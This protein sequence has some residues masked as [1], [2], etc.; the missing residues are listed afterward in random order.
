M[1]VLVN[2]MIEL[3]PID[4]LHLSFYLVPF[5]DKEKKEKKARTKHESLI[6]PSIYRK[7]ILLQ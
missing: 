1:T 5:R 6:C 7:I 2:V 4:L 3:V